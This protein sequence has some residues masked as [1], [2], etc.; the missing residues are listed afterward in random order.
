MRYLERPLR[1]AAL[2]FVLVL[3][4][5][6]TTAVQIEPSFPVRA[7]VDPLPIPIGVYYDEAFRTYLLAEPVPQRGD[8]EIDIGAAQVAMFRAILPSLFASVDELDAP[9]DPTAAAAVLV[10]RVDDMQFAIPFQTKSNFFEVWI[11]YRMELREPVSGA[12]IASWPLTAYGRTRDAFLDS[13]Q[14]AIQQAATTALR[15]A[16]AFLAIDFR[17]TS[18]VQGWLD[19][20][21]RSPDSRPASGPDAAPDSAPDSVPS[22]IEDPAPAARG[23]GEP[24]LESA[25]EG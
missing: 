19:A 12:L 2:L 15:D 9:T 7:V 13:A 23:P 16:A 3:A 1:R 6:T 21:L 24:P 18:E 22:S 25:V 17:N 4:G 5:C 10:P 20:Q 11:R 8:W 14:D